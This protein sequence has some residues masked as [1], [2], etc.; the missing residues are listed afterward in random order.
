MIHGWSTHVAARPAAKKPRLEETP[1]A[2]TESA[3]VAAAEEETLPPVVEETVPVEVEVALTDAG[4]TNPWEVWVGCVEEIIL[5]TSGDHANV[6]SCDIWFDPQYSFRSA[7]TQDGRAFIT[8]SQGQEAPCVA[9]E[10]SGDGFEG[11]HNSKFKIWYYDILWWLFLQLFFRGLWGKAPWFHSRAA[12]ALLISFQVR[13]FL[14][15]KASHQAG[16]TGSTEIFTFKAFTRSHSWSPNKPLENFKKFQEISRHFKNFQEISRYT[17]S[18]HLPGISWEKELICKFESRESGDARAL[19][20]ASWV[21]SFRRCA[22]VQGW[23]WTQLAGDCRWL[24]NG[25]GQFLENP[26]LSKISK[27]LFF[28]VPLGCQHATASVNSGVS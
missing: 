21:A 4:A 12:Q 7:G 2:S 18:I 8:I 5:E 6:E 15:P 28:M 26:V 9:F 27:I 3:E 24:Q 19:L 17:I 25:V 16:S 20:G 22:S 11:E 14:R 10:F 23:T 13:Q 1:A